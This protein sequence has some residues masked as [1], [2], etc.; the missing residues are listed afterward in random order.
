MNIL[1]II[2]LIV[3]VYLLLI[4]PNLSR[5]DA[6]LPYH[7]KLICHRG[8]FNNEDVP[9]NSL[10]AFRKAVEN[11]YGIELD[12]QITSD[13]KLVVFH[14]DDLYRMTGVHRIL[15]DCTFEELQQ[16]PLLDTKETIP[17]FSEVIKLLKPDTPLI[18]E[19]KEE[20]RY[21]QVT[22]E[23]VAMMK[24]YDG[25]YNMESF[26]PLVV[27]WLRDN[28][29]QI[30]R[31]QLS[32]NYLEDPNS[33]LSIFMKFIL[34]NLLLNIFTRPD[35]V[36]YDYNGR[37][38]LS[39]QI[40]SRLYKGEC[41]AWTIKSQDQLETARKYYRTFIFDSFIPKDHS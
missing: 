10:T 36:A 24:D 37:N 23:T 29:P 9:E 16:Y 38:N 12:V 4:F 1:I 17:L 5:K 8:L 39:F 6:L 20:R 7:K 14:D 25:L 35:Y 13:D 32:Y 27:K 34:T 21:A 11:G 22:K 19:I 15:N 3:A 26:N 33:H 30:I 18:I 40:I 2:G 41:V 28:A 31:G